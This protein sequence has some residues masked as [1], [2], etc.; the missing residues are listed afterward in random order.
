MMIHELEKMCRQKD[1][2]TATAEDIICKIDVNQVFLSSKYGMDTTLLSCAADE[3][4]YKMVELLLKHGANPNLVYGEKHHEENVLWELQYSS[5]DEE[6][7]V[8]RLN[9][10]KLLLENGANPHLKVEGA[11]LL[12]WAISN[13]GKD[14]GLQDK[15]RFEFINLL[16]KYDA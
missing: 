4:N 7:D 12:Q 10:V 16:E 8:I 13:W 6:E 3:A 11:D 2:E 1:F 5:D 15:Y 14:E 9:I